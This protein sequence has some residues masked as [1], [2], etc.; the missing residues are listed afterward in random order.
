LEEAYLIFYGLV[1]FFVGFVAFL[2]FAY[3]LDP[4]FSLKYRKAPTFQYLLF[5]STIDTLILLFIPVFFNLALGRDIIVVFSLSS[6]SL[7]LQEIFIGLLFGV[8]LFFIFL[9]VEMT[10]TAFRRKL[11][12]SYKSSREEELQKLVFNSLPKSQ[13][14][15]F[16]L[17]LITSVKA[18]LFEEII[19]RGYLMSQM[20]LLTVPAIAIIIQ[21]FLFFIPHL[22]QG[23]FNAIF[24]FVLGILLGLIFF[25]TGSLTVVIISHFTGDLIGLFIQAVLTERKKKGK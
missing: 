16:I 13:K 15:S 23:V 2:L 6:L 10:V 24:P 19:F 11:F 4:R 22:Y 9:P 25:L 7:T 14:K 20:L 17:L 8:L 3:K 12:S 1:A 21:A 5:L 18:A